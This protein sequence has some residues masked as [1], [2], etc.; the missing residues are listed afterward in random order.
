MERKLRTF[1]ILDSYAWV[2]YAQQQSSDELVEIEEEELLH[3]DSL[4]RECGEV[5][6][7]DEEGGGSDSTVCDAEDDV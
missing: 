1:K 4:R 6:V 7:S 2:H 5:C 3:D